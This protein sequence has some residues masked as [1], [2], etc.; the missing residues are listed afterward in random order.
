VQRVLDEAAQRGEQT[1]DHAFVRGLELGLAL[2]VAA[3]LAVLALR[4]SAP[5]SKSAA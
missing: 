2:I 3:A 1:I 5:R 4:R